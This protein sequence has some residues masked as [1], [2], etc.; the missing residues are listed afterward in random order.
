MDI[1]VIG[2]WVLMGLGTVGV[3]GAVLVSVKQTAPKGLWMMWFFSFAILGVGVYGPAFLEPYSKF[4]QPL[5]A[6]QQSP[7]ATTY[8]AVFEDVASGELPPEYQGIALAYALE[9]PVEGMEELL[10]E[11]ISA[12]TDPVGKLALRGARES[13][14][15]KKRVAAELLRDQELTAER[16]ERF[17][18]ATRAMVIRPLLKLSDDSLRERNLRRDVITALDA[19][20]TRRGG[21]REVTHDD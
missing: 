2:P 16:I 4:I 9:R 11:A 10:D 6:M 8:K 3:L 12:S 13:L 17:D 7:S 1:Q 20:R 5:L 18:P 21:Q 19:P 15:G 14:D